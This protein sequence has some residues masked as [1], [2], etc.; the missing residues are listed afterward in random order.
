[1]A[2]KKVLLKK[3][4]SIFIGTNEK[5]NKKK[6]TSSLVSLVPVLAVL[7][8]CLYKQGREIEG[9]FRVNG[10]VSELLIL[11]ESV[12]NRGGGELTSEE[13]GDPHVVAGLIKLFLRELE[14][15]LMLFSVYDHLLGSL[16]VKED[17]ARLQVMKAIIDTLPKENRSILFKL[18]D[19]FCLISSNEPITKMSTHNLAVVMGPTI[20]RPCGESFDTMMSDS[21]KVVSVVTILIENV[22]YFSKGSGDAITI[23]APVKLNEQE[24]DQLNPALKTDRRDVKKKY[25]ELKKTH[26]ELLESFDELR[27]QHSVLEAYSA[28]M[29]LKVAELED[30]LES[31]EHTFPVI[32]NDS[33]NNMPTME[34]TDDDVTKLRAENEW[35]REVLIRAT[36]EDMSNIREDTIKIKTPRE[37]TTTPSTG[38]PAK[39]VSTTSLVCEATSETEDRAAARKSVKLT[40]S[41]MKKQSSTKIM[42]KIIT[43][44]GPENPK[45]PVTQPPPPND[46]KLPLKSITEAN[47]NKPDNSTGESKSQTALRSRRSVNDTKTLVSSNRSS[48]PGKN[49]LTR[50]NTMN[51]TQLMR[52]KSEL[53]NENISPLLNSPPGTDQKEVQ[54]SEVVQKMIDLENQIFL[55]KDTERT[56]LRKHLDEIRSSVVVVAGTLSN[57]SQKLS[58]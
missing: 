8:E 36:R 24:I 42:Q 37:S 55:G 28:K 19:L 44:K 52:P 14:E 26:D 35:L 15:P 27:T 3:A 21:S 32:R 51:N 39:R 56:D 1:M 54:I 16:E 50:L 4:G 12:L 2:H 10:S 49:N 30:L 31:I 29:D 33:D 7:A 57:L 34:E 17:K 20:M 25:D 5:K 6:I 18:L 22:E 45:P 47:N 11:R 13:S 38:L 53:N 46:P 23:S 58:L 40:S 43:H 9:L 41:F 48:S